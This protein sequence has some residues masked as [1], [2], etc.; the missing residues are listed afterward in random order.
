MP[1]SSNEVIDKLPNVFVRLLNFLALILFKNIVVNE[2]TPYLM[3]FFNFNVGIM[4]VY[5]GFNVRGTTNL[6]KK[7]FYRRPSL[8]AGVRFQENPA[9]I[10]TRE[11]QGNFF[12]RQTYLFCNNIWFWRQN[13]R[14]IEGIIRGFQNL[15]SI[16]KPRIVKTADSKSANNEGRL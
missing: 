1:Y 5:I 16:R 12:S 7:L 2:F 4:V 3:I 15:V 8:F 10:K 13:P 11:Y 6:E 14:I 9:N